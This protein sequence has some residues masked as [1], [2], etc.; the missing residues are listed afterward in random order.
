MG[1][2][3]GNNCADVYSHILESCQGTDSHH[4]Q[5][6][7][8]SDLECGASYGYNIF[9]ENTSPEDDPRRS[10]VDTLKCAA[11]DK[12]SSGIAVPRDELSVSSSSWKYS[13]YYGPDV[14]I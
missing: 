1:R 10:Q 8:S 11:D 4:I 3:C 12:S 2:F 5:D 9:R 13:P 14:R 6:K 7:A